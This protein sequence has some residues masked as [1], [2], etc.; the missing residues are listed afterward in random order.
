[1]NTIGSHPGAII[2]R[3]SLMLIIV[4]ILIVKFFSYVGKSQRSFESASIRQ[5]KTI[6]DSLFASGARPAGYN[7]V[8][9]PFDCST[10]PGSTFNC[11]VDSAG[12]ATDTAAT[13]TIICTP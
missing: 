9:G 8:G 7:W 12:S 10:N 11:A 6:I 13:A 4:L 2:F 5:T 1:M 3:L